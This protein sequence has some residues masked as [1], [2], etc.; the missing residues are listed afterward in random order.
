MGRAQIGK[1]M[2]A[3]PD[4]MLGL[5]ESKHTQLQA[6]A[7]TAWVPSPS[8]AAVQALH[9]YLFDAR[10]AQIAEL[11]ERNEDLNHALFMPPLLKDRTLSAQ[12]IHDELEN[13]LQGILG[14]I[15]RWIDQGVCCSKIPNIHDVG[16]MEDRA[17]CQISSQI[18]ANWVQQEVVDRDQVEK[19]LTKAAKIVDQQNEHDENY[20]EI[21]SNAIVI[22]AARALIFQGHLEPSGYTEPILHQARLDKKKLR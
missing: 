1:G 11:T 21:S 2:W 19:M 12:K 17:T 18:V 8:A 22:S 14:Y 20:E 16:L 13:N 10:A 9:Y 5:F 4:N 6:G 7:T 3:E 15:V